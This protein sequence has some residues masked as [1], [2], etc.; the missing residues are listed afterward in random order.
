MDPSLSQKVY[1]HVSPQDLL[2]FDKWKRIQMCNTSVSTKPVVPKKVKRKENL[3]PTQ[4][5][6]KKENENS[7]SIQSCEICH[8]KSDMRCSRCHSVFYCSADHQKQ[9]WKQHKVKC[10]K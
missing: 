9:D 1:A 6:E 7:H 3:I 8:K 4:A 5:P 2:I 10:I